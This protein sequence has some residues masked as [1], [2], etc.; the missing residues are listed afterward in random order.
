MCLQNKDAQTGAQ[1]Q[2]RHEGDV[3]ANSSSKHTPIGITDGL[4]CQECC[5]LALLLSNYNFHGP[6]KVLGS[7]SSDGGN[8]V[9]AQPAPVLSKQMTSRRPAV[10][11]VC[12]PVTK[13]PILRSREMLN[14]M[15]M[16]KHAG[17]AG[18]TATVIMSRNLTTMRPGSAPILANTTAA[19]MKIPMQATCTCD[20][21]TE[22]QKVCGYHALIAIMQMAFGLGPKT[23]LWQGGRKLLHQASCR[24]CKELSVLQALYC[25]EVQEARTT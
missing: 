25:C 1:Q 6:E 24:T 15:A 8:H 14:T 21:H 4:Y 23:L 18:G 11:M 13:M 16:V 3:H 20:A 5:G 10:V 17:S 7:P 12:G 2:Y 22:T 9:A 19:Q